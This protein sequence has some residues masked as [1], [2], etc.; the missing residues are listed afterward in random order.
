[1]VTQ[2][3]GKGRIIAYDL[4]PMD[5]IVGVDFLQ[6]DF[7]DELCLKRYWIALATAKSGC[8]VG[9]GK[10]WRNTGSGY[11]RAMSGGTSVRN[12]VMY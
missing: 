4:L 12:V 5:P 2:I 10:I 8:H 1:M 6:G 9:Y 11:P 3:G 7:R